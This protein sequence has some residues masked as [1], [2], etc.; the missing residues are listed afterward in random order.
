MNLQDTLENEE[1][2][3]KNTEGLKNILPETWT[4]VSNLNGLQM[5][6]RFKL[7]GLDWRSDLDFGQIMVK[8]E[9]LGIMQR[10]TILIRRSI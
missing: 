3:T 6:W 2:L 9:K 8:L 4:H 1:W 7:V 5:A 10:D